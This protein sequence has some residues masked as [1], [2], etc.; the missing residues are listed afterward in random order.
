[1]ALIS[2]CRLGVHGNTQQRLWLSPAH[3]DS[4]FSRSS[5]TSSPEPRVSSSHPRHT[6][7]VKTVLMFAD[8]HLHSYPE[9]GVSLWLMAR[10]RNLY[11]LAIHNATVYGLALGLRYSHKFI[12]L[13]SE[14]GRHLNGLHCLLQTPEKLTGATVNLVCRQFC[15]YINS[16]FPASVRVTISETT[17]QC[18]QDI[19]KIPGKNFSYPAFFLT[20]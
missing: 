15:Y 16:P 20:N 3:Y 12:G 14:C 2:V 11:D 8:D 4:H 10:V 17:L 6:V 13:N 5:L 19:D 1:M 9:S 18:T 7:S